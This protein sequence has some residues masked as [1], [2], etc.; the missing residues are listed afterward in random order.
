MPASKSIAEIPRVQS[1]QSIGEGRVLR[2]LP[3]QTNTPALPVPGGAPLV[4]VNLG[5][6]LRLA[7][8][9]AGGVA[10]LPPG[11]AEAAAL[12]GYT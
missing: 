5:A 10:F 7:R 3:F 8:T 12:R 4:D 11:A 9:R 6:R 1:P 2:V